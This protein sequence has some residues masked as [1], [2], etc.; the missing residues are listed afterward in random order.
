VGWLGDRQLV[1]CLKPL[2]NSPQA[3]GA[4]LQIVM[5]HLMELLQKVGGLLRLLLSGICVVMV[6]RCCGVVLWWCC[7]PNLEFFAR[8]TLIQNCHETHAHMLEAH[9]YPQP[10]VLG[11][12][13]GEPSQGQASGQVLEA[14]SPHLPAGRVGPARSRVQ[15]ASVPVI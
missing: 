12:L 5:R 6:W 3:V 11:F 4:V 14:G 8:R 10:A 2:L 9:F 7:V 1:L 13:L 15:H